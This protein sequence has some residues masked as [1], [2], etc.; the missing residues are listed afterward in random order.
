MIHDGINTTF[1]EKDLKTNL[2]NLNQQWTLLKT[3]KNKVDYFD[4]KH[5]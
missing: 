3:N 5:Y 2:N 1:V 4:S